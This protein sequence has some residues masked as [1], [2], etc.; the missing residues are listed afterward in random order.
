MVVL[1]AV[2]SVTLTVFVPD[3]S[4]LLPNA[5]AFASEDVSVTVS[6]TFV[7]IFQFGSTA[8]MVTLKAVPAVWVDGVPVLPVAL[9]GAAVSPGTNSCSF[10]NTPGLTVIGELVPA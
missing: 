5:E 3:T 2:L 1:P 8:L 7:I 9:P 4:E 10:V 6:V